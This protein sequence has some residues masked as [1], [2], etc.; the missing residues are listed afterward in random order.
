[1]GFNLGRASSKSATNYFSKAMNGQGQSK[2]ESK[3][4]SG[5]ISQRSGH[6][7][8]DK[9]HSINTMKSFRNVTSQYTQFLKDKFGSIKGNLNTTTAT[10]WLGDKLKNDEEFKGSSANTYISQLGNLQIAADKLGNKCDIDLKEIA[11]N[12][13][14]SGYDLGKSATDRSFAD[15]NS[16]VSEMQ[17]SQ[18]AISA[19][20]QIEAGM[21]VDD[22][23][24]STKWQINQDNTITIHGSKNGLNYTTREL[25]QELVSRAIEAKEQGYKASYTSYSTDLKEV[26]NNQNQAWQGTHGLRYDYAQSRFS[27]LQ[28]QG[29]SYK[30]SLANVS[31]EMGHSRIEITLHYLNI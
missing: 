27:E 12:L 23:I 14:D 2:V 8:S 22:A 13:R 19:S 16:L 30:E 6:N 5:L 7:K 28:Q 21:R 10:R 17:N 29:C 24:N 3:N 26:A 25:N 20:L 18:Y 9:V 15:A 1:M 4:T 11:G 31:L